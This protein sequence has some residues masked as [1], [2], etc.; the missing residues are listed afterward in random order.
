MF[1]VDY[2]DGKTCPLREVCQRYTDY[3]YKIHL[4]Q[5]VSDAHMGVSD[6]C[7]WFDAK[8]FVGD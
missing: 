8:R 3:L 1:T 2:C 4:K 6:N 7:I 5:D